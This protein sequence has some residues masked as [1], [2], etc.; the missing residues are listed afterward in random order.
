MSIQCKKQRNYLF[1]TGTHDSAFNLSSK[2]C[3]RLFSF[4]GI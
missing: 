4:A 1:S 2:V 3:F